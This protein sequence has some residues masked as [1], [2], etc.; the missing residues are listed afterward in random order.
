MYYV[1]IDI[2]I[3]HCEIIY[4]IPKTSYTFFNLI[5]PFAGLK[6]KLG[7]ISPFFW[8]VEY[9]NQSMFNWPSTIFWSSTSGWDPFPWDVSESG[10]FTKQIGV[11]ALRFQMER[12]D[13]ARVMVAST[14]NGAL[15][16]WWLRA[17]QHGLVI[18]LKIS[19]AL[20]GIKLHAKMY[21][22]IFPEISLVIVHIVSVWD[23]CC[24]WPFLG[25][26][27]QLQ[28]TG[29]ELTTTDH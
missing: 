22:H 6:F 9:I 19:H 3:I 11:E 21:D 28:I 13:R 4:T 24:S 27:W 26:F 2:D 17:N 15:C 20:K 7:T 16:L 25:D 23:F 1:S 29:P 18:G 14:S 12:A 8:E 10:W 5:H